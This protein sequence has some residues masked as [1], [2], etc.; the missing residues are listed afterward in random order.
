MG[1]C[2]SVVLGNF[3]FHGHWWPVNIERI[4]DKTA[5]LLLSRKIDFLSFF[6]SLSL[7]FFPTSMAFSLITKR[8]DSWISFFQTRVHPDM[9]AS[10]IKTNQF[11]IDTFSTDYEIY[12]YIYRNKKTKIDRSSKM[13]SV[14][15]EM[16]FWL[17]KQVIILYV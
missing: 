4:N 7:S 3:P 16:R 11:P 5:C 15:I 13:R 8:S 14:T 17:K 6:F 12:T 9:I 10:V 1:T 2:S